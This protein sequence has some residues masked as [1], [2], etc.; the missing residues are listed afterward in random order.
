VRL[1]DVF[2]IAPFLIYVGS[3]KS[4]STP[5]RATLWGIGLATLFY[6]G[7]HYLKNKK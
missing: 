1:L 3:N 6:N 5:V 7:H 4:L 2:F